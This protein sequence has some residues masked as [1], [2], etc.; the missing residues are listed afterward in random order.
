MKI[1]NTCS[2]IFLCGLISGSPLSSASEKVA[3]A[4]SLYVLS[5]RFVS[6]RYQANFV[7]LSEHQLRRQRTQY[8]N[9]L[10][11]EPNSSIALSRKMARTRIQL[12][13]GGTYPARMGSR[14]RKTAQSAQSILLG[15]LMDVLFMT[16]R[17]KSVFGLMRLSVKSKKG[18]TRRVTITIRAGTLFT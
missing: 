15:V 12:I 17:G 7:T 4:E 14:R 6:I 18:M 8:I 1:S 9:R 10:Q 16:Q 2:I 13:V 3:D 5:C 11:P